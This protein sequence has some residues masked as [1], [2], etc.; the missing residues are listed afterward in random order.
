[1]ASRSS[2]SGYATPPDVQTYQTVPRTQLAGRLAQGG[3][4]TITESCD[5]A[6]PPT[7]LDQLA[8]DVAALSDSST[9]TGTELVGDPEMGIATCIIEDGIPVARWVYSTWQAWWTHKPRP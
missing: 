9:F 7:S 4:E 5:I 2:G 6:L 8:A 1:V 3:H